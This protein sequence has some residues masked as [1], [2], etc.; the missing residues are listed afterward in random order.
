MECQFLLTMVLLSWA[1]T[2]AAETCL[3]VSCGRQIYVRYVE[4]FYLPKVWI[5]LSCRPTFA[6]VVAAPMQKLWPA[7]ASALSPAAASSLQMSAT[8]L[9]RVR[10]HTGTRGLFVCPRQPSRGA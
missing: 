8:N 9:R 7:Y 10:K 4:L 2:R 6:A 3:N 5:T 1:Q